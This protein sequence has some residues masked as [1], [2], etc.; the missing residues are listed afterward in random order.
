MQ[1]DIAQRI[2]KEKGVDIANLA[3][4]LAEALKKVFGGECECENCKAEREAKKWE[5]NPEQKFA[6]D[7]AKQ[8]EEK[9]EV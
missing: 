7:L 3:K 8:P 9:S 2:L 6:E 4:G 1:R 5:P